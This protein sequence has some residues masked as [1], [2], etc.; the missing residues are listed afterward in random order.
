M[1]TLYERMLAIQTKARAE[2]RTR[3]I[4]ATGQRIVREMAAK[5]DLPPP[6]PTRE[7]I[8]EAIGPNVNND[9]GKWGKPVECAPFTGPEADEYHKTLPPI[10][11]PARDAWGRP[12]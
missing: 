10:V 2:Q 5:V 4:T 1:S 7:A 12:K 3:E 11:E 9:F 6:D 8:R